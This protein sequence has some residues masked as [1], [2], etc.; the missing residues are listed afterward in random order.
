M[1]EKSARIISV[2]FHPVL[3]PTLGFILL[4]NTEFYFSFLSWE[5]KRFVLLVLF[6]TTAVLPMLSVAILTL[7]R[8]YDVA[9][10]KSNDR[11]LPLLFSSVFYYLGYLLLSKIKAYPVF[12]IYMLAAVLVIIF[13]MVVSLKW[14]ISTH[15]AAIGSLTAALLSL[16]FRTGINPL[17]EVLLVVIVSGIIGSARIIAAKHSIWEIVS[18]YLTGF[19]IVYLVIYFA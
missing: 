18:G 3:I 1:L 10:K 16:S 7:N 6:F 9:M 5:A 4:F 11:V 8:K 2:I 17:W 19:L 15:M 13:L 14:K 12:K